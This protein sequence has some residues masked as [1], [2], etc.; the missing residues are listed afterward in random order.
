[1]D[2]YWRKKAIQ[3]LTELDNW[4]LSLELPRIGEFLQQNIE[5]YFKYQDFSIYIP[6]KTVFI[7]GSP[8]ELR[9]V[10]FRIGKSDPY[11]VY[12][13]LTSRS[14]EIFLVKHPRQKPLT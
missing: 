9:L 10:L 7:K 1:M 5:S 3:S 4:R 6:G 8:I 2:I 14:V 11:K 12:Y 13:R